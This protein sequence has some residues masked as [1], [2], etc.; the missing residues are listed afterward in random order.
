MLY[1]GLTQAMMDAFDNVPYEQAVINVILADSTTMTLTNADIVED[2]LVIDRYTTYNNS[3]SF[4]TC[5][6]AE[7]TLK[8]NNRDGRFDSVVFNN[9]ILIT[10]VDVSGYNI[11]L[12]RFRV[13]TPPR[14]ASIINIY[15]LDD[16]VLLD[17]PLT[18][19]K[20]IKTGGYNNR[21]LTV[22]DL[23]ERI[24]KNC[25]PGAQVNVNIANSPNVGKMIDTENIPYVDGILTCRQYCAWLAGLMGCVLES[26]EYTT[27]NCIWYKLGKDV[28]DNEL[29][30][31]SNPSNRYSFDL[32]KKP[33]EY[34][35]VFYKDERGCYNAGTTEYAFDVSNNK[36]LNCTYN[37]DTGLPY[38]ISEMIFPINNK[39]IYELQGGMA[40]YA[41][42]ATVKAAPYLFPGDPIDLYIDEVVIDDETG[43]PIH[44]LVD[45]SSTITHVTHKLNG[46]TFIAAEGLSQEEY[47]QVLPTGSGTATGG[48]ALIGNLTVAGT[49]SFSGDI[50]VPYEGLLKSVLIEMVPATSIA[51][52]GY[53]YNTYTIAQSEIGA[54]WTPIAIAGHIVNNRYVS[55]YNLRVRT[56]DPMQ[57]TYGLYNTSTAARSTSLIVNVLCIR[58]SL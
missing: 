9:A 52:E 38:S 13:I 7:M 40:Y 43:E 44:T 24:I 27:I 6:C 15:A 46:A 25:I 20:F 51:A 19:D 32:E 29:V 57:V 23:L 8:L 4:G 42:S 18:P 2:G 5:V 55:V 37:Q 33:I 17:V 41:F 28:S 34:T 48:D 30:Y 39:R 54:G 45:Y 50:A 22:Y 49:A 53:L 56:D 26:G 11:Y 47:Q 14:N 58:T 1:P 36:L 3:L 12:G 35:G 21:Y 31:E 10:R 16:M